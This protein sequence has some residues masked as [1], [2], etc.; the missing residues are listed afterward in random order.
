MSRG[1]MKLSWLAMTSTGPLRGI[2]PLPSVRRL[3]PSV[4]REYIRQKFAS[5]H[6]AGAQLGCI[7]GA[8]LLAGQL[9]AKPA[10]LGLH[11]VHHFIEGK[12]GTVDQDRV[13]GRAHGRHV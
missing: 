10:N 5:Y 4:K 2:R 8:V 1:S 6:S 3:K 13:V 11:A 9:R 12:S 7:S